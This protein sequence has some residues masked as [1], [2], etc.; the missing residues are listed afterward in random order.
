MIGFSF[1]TGGRAGGLGDPASLA[2]TLLCR[3]FVNPTW[4]GTA[5]LGTSGSNSLT[6]P[7][8]EPA[9]GT[10]LNGHGTANFNGTNDYFI[11]SGTLDTYF[12]STTFSGWVL[13]SPD[14]VS[15]DRCVLEDSANQFRLS[16][17]GGGATIGLAINGVEYVTRAITTGGYR[18]VTFRFDGST[19]QIGVNEIPGAAGGGSTAAAATSM[20]LAGSLYVGTLNGA[21]GDFYD[22]HVAEIVLTDFALNDSQFLAMRTYINQRYALSI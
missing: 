7:G 3:D 8:N 10:A 9:Q 12:A 20:T 14:T 16:I 13:L 6:D 18:W 15:T 11:A 17:A 21:S 2:M 22:G 19:A 5:S 4:T 1:G